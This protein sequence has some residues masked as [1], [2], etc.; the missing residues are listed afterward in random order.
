[1]GN[2]HKNFGPRTLELRAQFF[3]IICEG[4]QRCPYSAGF[5]LPFFTI[6]SGKTIHG[7][8]RGKRKARRER[9]GNEGSEVYLFPSLLKSL[10][11]PTPSLRDGGRETLETVWPSFLV[12][13][14]HTSRLK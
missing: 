4:R 1:M 3:N 14:L 11:L 9:E 8:V 10:I 2:I 6:V 13:F 5:S 12:F 7:W